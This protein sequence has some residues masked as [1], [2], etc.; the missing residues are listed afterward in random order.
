M[1]APLLALLLAFAP[2]TTEPT[3]L[4]SDD[5]HDLANWS[6]ELQSGGTVEARDGKL[7]IDV[8][9]GCTVWFKPP[10]DGPVMIE[11][12]ATVISAGG[13]NDRV[14]DLNCFWMARDARSP[15]DLFAT[16]R[17]GK[18]EDYNRLLC[19]Y[20]GLGG[21]GNTTTRFRRY[22]GHKELRPLLPEHDRSD[23]A[24]MIVPNAAQT[25]RLVA[26]GKTIQFWRDD[27]KIFEMIDPQP[28]TKGHFG[29]RTTQN[30]MEIRHFRVYRMK[31]NDGDR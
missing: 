24:S 10:L 8:P 21:N 23:K 14:S 13:N 5:F 20:V 17:S 18:F 29:F 26:N 27:R 30:H 2:P 28:Y 1:T 7:V 25:I 3:C 15:D 19:Y 22:I 31:E 16:H 12:E 6:V 4:H 9:A 11:Y